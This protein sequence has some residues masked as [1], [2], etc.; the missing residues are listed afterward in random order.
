VI[1]NTRWNVVAKGGLVLHILSLLLLLLL[2]KL[3]SSV[4]CKRS[5]VSVTGALFVT[6]L[7]A[8]RFARK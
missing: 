8:V 3:S 7:C 4:L 1:I 5:V 2:H 6:G